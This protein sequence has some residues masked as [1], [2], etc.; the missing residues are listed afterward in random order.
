MNRPSTTEIPEIARAIDELAERLATTPG[1]WLK[2]INAMQGPKI[3]TGTPE[4]NPDPQT[5]ISLHAFA[6]VIA[7]AM[8]REAGPLLK[9]TILKLGEG[10]S[11]GILGRSFFD[12][13]R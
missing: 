11:L 1:L 7:D 4:I 10:V 5:T 6:G 13:L 2:L 3:V 12:D 9:D 8:L